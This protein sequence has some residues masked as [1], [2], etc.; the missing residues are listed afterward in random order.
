MDTGVWKDMDIMVDELWNDN[1]VLDEYN[2]KSLYQEHVLEQYKIIE[3][4]S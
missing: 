4:K 1:I 2:K 3:R